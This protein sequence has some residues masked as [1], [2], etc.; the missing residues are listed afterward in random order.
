MGTKPTAVVYVDAFNLYRRRLSDFPDTKWLN[1][2]KLADLVLPDYEIVGVEYFTAILRYSTVNDPAMVMRQQVYLRAL[3]T[4]ENFRIH[5]GAF[6]SDKRTMTIHPKTVDPETGEVKRIAVI[7]VEEKGSDVNLATR[8]VADSLSNRSDIAVIL[9]NDS[10][11]AGQIRMLTEEF[12]KRV[13]LI[14]PLL[15][16][17][18]ASKELKNLLIEFFREI[19]ADALFAAQFPETINDKHGTIHRPEAWR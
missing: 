10:D 5:L 13:G 3:D 7:K 8:M 14:T 2:N 6:R 1:L 18:R 4:L 17:K 11:H 12:G 9:S 16:S 19:S 15:E